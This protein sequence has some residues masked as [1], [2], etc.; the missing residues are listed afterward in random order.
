MKEN[1]VNII[2][3]L[4]DADSYITAVKKA[5]GLHESKAA[6]FIFL[7]NCRVTKEE[8]LIR[9][10]LVTDNLSILPWQSSLL[11]EGRKGIAI[12]TLYLELKKFLLAGNHFEKFEK[13]FYNAALFDILH[14]LQEAETESEYWDIATS[15]KYYIEDAFHFLDKPVTYYYDKDWIKE[16]LDRVREKPDNS[17]FVTNPKI[18][19]VI[20]SLNSRPYIRECVESAI[21]QNLKDVEILCVDAG[22]DDGTLEVLREYEKL[23]RRVIVIQSD[24]KSYGYQIN[25]GIKAAKGEYLAILESDDYIAPEMY[26]ELYDVAKQNQIEVIKADFEIFTG[27]KGRHEFIHRHVAKK[28][29]QYDKIIDPTEDLEVFKNTNIPWSGL[30]EMNFLRRNNI[31][32]NESPGA[33][34]QDNGLWFQSLC[35]THRLYYKSSSYY[36]LRRDNPESSVYSRNKVFCICDEYEF[37]RNTLRKSPELEKKFAPLC[38]RF[39]YGSYMWRFNRI[40]EEFKPDFLQRFAEDFRK[41]AGSGEL[42]C[43]LFPESHWNTLNKIMQDPT[44]Y[45]YNNS[46]LTYEFIRCLPPERYPQ[47]L[48]RWFNKETGRNLDLQ[49]PVTFDEKIQWLKLYDNIPIKTQLADKFKVREWVKEKIGEEYLIP[50]LGVWDKFKDINFEELPQSFVLKP[51]HG[52]GW[53]IIVKNKNELDISDAKKKFEE[54]MRFNFATRGL[55]LQYSDIIPKIIAEQ[56]LDSVN[57]KRNDYKV[58]C[59]GGKAN[60]VQYL[61][62]RKKDLKMVFYDLKWEKLSFVYKNRIENAHIAKPK[63]LELLISLAETLSQGFAFVR[64]DFYVLD[65]GSIKF[66][67]MTFTPHNG[68]MKWN[69]PEQDLV[70][71]KLIN[72]PY[73]NKTPLPAKSLAEKGAVPMPPVIVLPKNPAN[74]LTER[75]KATE[76]EAANLQKQ[77][78]RIRNSKAFYIGEKLAW[79]VRVIRNILKGKK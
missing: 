77:L 36:R 35:Q 12:D 33:S 70:F 73:N 75:M 65:D 1:E 59:F 28:F 42:D 38:A 19:V 21:E 44:A 23:D 52:S 63:N 57:N 68:T 14:A 6:E 50:I 71:G 53:Y 15:I 49:N 61:S 16:Y 39:R 58:Y 34:Y 74:M 3:P 60:C 31:L 55:Q 48:K 30:Y 78:V 5:A 56:Y 22:S 24:K 26:E 20:P 64:V 13:A 7:D 41:L 51:N 9:S 72:L 37:I 4:H 67:E 62:G 40:A 29:E 25:L 66:G 27:G 8:R 43:S 47:I 17:Y 11:K 54:W 32:L 76:H 79:P 10:F 18:T 69:P 46:E 45:Y 2:V